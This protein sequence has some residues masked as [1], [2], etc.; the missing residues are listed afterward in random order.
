MP[1]LR[2]RAADIPLIC[3]SLRKIYSERFDRPTR[4]LSARKLELL[5]RYHWPGNIRELENLIKRDIILGSED[6][7]TLETTEGSA[8]LPDSEAGTN[9]MLSLKKGTREAMPE[10]EGK[11][12]VKAV[13]T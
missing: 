6:V 13:P 3:D 8:A 12:I 9:S 2:E 11:S 5:Q 10:L 1:T 7:I 4:P